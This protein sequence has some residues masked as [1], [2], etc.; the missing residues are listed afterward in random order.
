MGDD[1]QMGYLLVDYILR[2]QGHKRVG[3]IRSSNRY[4]RFGVREVNDSCR[5]LGHP[6]VLEMAYKVGAE[7][8]SLQLER[9][10]QSNLDVIV[11]WGD[12]REGALILNQMRKMGMTQPFLG[13][14]RTVSDEFVRLAGENAE[15]VVAGFPWNPERK[16]PKLDAFRAAFRKRFGEEAE[17]YA[18]HGYDGMNML[19][20]GIQVAGLNRAKIR[21]VIAYRARPWPGVT[22]D[23][24]LSSVLDDTGEVFLA[25]RENGKWKYYSREELEIP[26]GYVP[27]ASRVKRTD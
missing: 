27:R 20:W 12:A 10:K 22:G 11:H 5:R 24:Q 25:K 17:T 7:D 16:D 19:I 6:M 8:F 14:D 15:G 3:I 23:I 4:G 2:K 21:D 13:C 1:R 9:L 18:A 26:R